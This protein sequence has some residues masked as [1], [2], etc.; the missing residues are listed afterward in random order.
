MKQIFYTA[1]NISKIYLSPYISITARTEDSIYLANTLTEET[2]RFTG[3]QDVINKLM[4]DLENGSDEE[5]II[6]LLNSLSPK[7]EILL[8]YQKGFLE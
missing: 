1:K 8:L 7:V 4:N 6:S 2:V 3:E 5:N